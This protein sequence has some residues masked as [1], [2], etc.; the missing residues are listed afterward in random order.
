MKL[1]LILANQ[2]AQIWEISFP[3]LVF[4]I[5]QLTDDSALYV[6]YLLEQLPI[7]APILLVI[8]F[9]NVHQLKHNPNK[10][11]SF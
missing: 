3:K 8:S 10:S 1:V 7:E 4:T 2:N 6:K 11:I 5:N 9:F